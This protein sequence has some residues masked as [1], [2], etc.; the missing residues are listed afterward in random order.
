MTIRPWL[1]AALLACSSLC[2]AAE[3]VAVAVFA[4]D[5]AARR[6]E[7]AVQTRLEEA[8]RE[9]GYETL[10]QK[11]AEKI[12]NNWTDN[13][14][15]GV[16]LTAEEFS[17][18]TE[19]MAIDKVYRVSFTVGSSHPMAL[20]YSATGSVQISLHG[21]MA[22][23]KS[24]TSKPMGVLGYAP[25][26][27]LTEDAAI[28]NA[29]QRSV[30]SALEQ[31]GVQ[32]LAPVS[33]R[34]VPLALAPVAALPADAA[35]MSM[36][37]RAAAP[38]WDK[39]ARVL[40][41]RWRR[42]DPACQAVSGDGA[43][44]VHGTYAWIGGPLGRAHGGYLHLVDIAGAREV[45]KLTLH[46]L[47]ARDRGDNGSSAALACSFLGNWRYL[48][49]ASGNKIVCFDVE[50]GIQTCSHAVLGAPDQAALKFWQSGARR[51][52]VL[53]SG[54]GQQTFELTAGPNR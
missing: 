39:H 32:V 47:G 1:C 25:S 43:M 26:D 8:L 23:V 6:Y 22:A 14:E 54:K 3:R 41:E 38:G 33:A 9:A 16:L 29:L 10:D 5:P 20:F 2:S 37:S 15:P 21:P 53:A 13:I 17:K 35:E 27:A 12:K 50:R 44:G 4:A 24:S 51:Y 36:G 40:A 31:S 19:K 46:E 28:V 48:I 49:A 52:V 45:A 18:R 34:Y 30:E 42:E 11:E 7:R